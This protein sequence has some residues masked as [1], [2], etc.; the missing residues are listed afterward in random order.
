MFVKISNI[1]F[2]K[3]KNKDYTLKFFLIIV[4]LKA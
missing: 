3:T 1:F 2:Y 4:E